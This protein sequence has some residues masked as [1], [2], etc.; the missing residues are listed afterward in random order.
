MESPEGRHLA[1]EKVLQDYRREDWCRTP[2][3]RLSVVPPLGKVAEDD[4]FDFL[5]DPANTS[6][7]PSIRA[8]VAQRL[9]RETGGDFEHTVALIEEAEAGSWYDLLYRLRDSQGEKVTDDDQT[10]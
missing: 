5:D 9:H 8:K 2:V 3:F 4:L 7:D 6:C 10:F 1:L